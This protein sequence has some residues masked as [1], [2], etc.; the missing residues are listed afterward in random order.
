V[1]YS[2]KALDIV[3]PLSMADAMALAECEITTVVLK[4]NCPVWQ[5]ASADVDQWPMCRLKPLMCVPCLALFCPTAL[6]VGSLGRLHYKSSNARWVHSQCSMTRPASCMRN[7]D[8]KSSAQSRLK[9]RNHSM[10]RSNAF[11]APFLLL[12]HSRFAITKSHC[13]YMLEHP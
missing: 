1:T 5:P 6:T 9:R 13:T 7:S 3:N 4:K 8:R 2:V 12:S 11:S 10:L